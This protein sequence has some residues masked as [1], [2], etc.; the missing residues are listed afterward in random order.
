MKQQLKE[1]I[2]DDSKMMQFIRFGLNGVFATA[3]HYGVYLLLQQY[4]NVNI[5]YTIGYL[6]SF[7]F[8]FIMTSYFTF[9]SRPSWK[10]FIGFSGSHAVNYTIE[11]CVLNLCIYLGVD[12]TI[13]P[14]PAMM[15]AVIVQFTILRFVFSKKKQ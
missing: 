14:I 7:A 9:Q 3:I 15:A 11:I 6:V 12:K 10:K 8:N 2:K 4:I 5:A 13:A 1:K